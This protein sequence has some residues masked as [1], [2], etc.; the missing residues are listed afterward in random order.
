VK[1]SSSF[2]VIAAFSK[3]TFICFGQSVKLQLDREVH[4]A[5][6]MDVKF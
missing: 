3:S 2:T 1:P 6:D 4:T 5:H